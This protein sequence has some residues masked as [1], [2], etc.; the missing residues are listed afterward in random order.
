MLSFYYFS[1]TTNIIMGIL[2]VLF[3]GNDD[4]RNEKYPI[5]KD[6][7]FLLI[8]MVVSGIFAVLTLLSPIEGSLPVIGDLIPSVTGILGCIV[9]FKRWFILSNPEKEFPAFFEKVIAYEKIIGY[10][11]LAAGCVHLFVPHIIF[12]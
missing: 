7:T 5:V 2:L 9:L 1:V 8:L 3:S 6:T 12:L 11:C 10:C 4:E